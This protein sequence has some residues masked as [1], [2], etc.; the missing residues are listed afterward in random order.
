MDDG[1]GRSNDDDDGGGDID[2]VVDIVVEIGDE[3]GENDDLGSN[4]KGG[5]FGVTSCAID[6]SKGRRRRT[7]K[8]QLYSSTSSN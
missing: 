2:I 4:N 6:G 3:K 8:M 5:M 1:A 7:S